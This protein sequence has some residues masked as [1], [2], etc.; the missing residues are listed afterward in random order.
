MAAAK[1]EADKMPSS[2][3]RSLTSASV[4]AAI[5]VATLGVGFAGGAAAAS[6]QCAPRKV[7]AT[8]GN[9]AM[10]YF[11]KSKARAAWIRKVSGDVRLGP[12]YA[13]W[14]R[15]A[16]RRTLCRAVD[17][18]FVCLAVALPCRSPRVVVVAPR[19][20]QSALTAPSVRLVKPARSL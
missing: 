13:Q 14:L 16:D 2:M 12:N 3:R 4:A 15:A 19:E 8:G 11:A 5:S 18:R 1:G 10:S 7:S 6:S 17:N 20:K 9:S